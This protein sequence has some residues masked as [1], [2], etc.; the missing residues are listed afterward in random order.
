MTGRSRLDPGRRASM[1]PVT[2]FRRSHVAI[3]T[4]YTKA[5]VH[6]AKL[7]NKVTDDREIVI[8]N[9]RGH[10]NVA[11]ITASDLSSLMETAYLL[12]SPKNARR[13]LEAIRRSQANEIRPSSVEELRREFGLDREG[14]TPDR[15]LRP[16]LPGRSSTL[17]GARAQAG[18]PPARSGRSRHARSVPRR[19]KA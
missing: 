4:S 16:R 12:R 6:L 10:E 1:F 17:R 8:I 15:N 2:P 13:L 19:G 7:L 5:R 11:L 14:E 3:E 9:R 18:A